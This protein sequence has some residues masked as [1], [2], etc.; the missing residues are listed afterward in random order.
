MSGNGGILYL[1]QSPNFVT[2]KE[3]KNQFQGTSSARLY[4][5]AGRYDNPIPPRFLAPIRLFKNSITGRCSKTAKRKYKIIKDYLWF[6][7]A[8]HTEYLGQI[9]VNVK[10]VPVKADPPSSNAHALAHSHT[11]SPVRGLELAARYLSHTQRWRI[12]VEVS[13][14]D[15]LKNLF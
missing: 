3:P 5:L 11:P 15:I 12:E 7:I 2:L 14:S 13:P 6:W 1:V 9:S 4:S 10:L 8:G